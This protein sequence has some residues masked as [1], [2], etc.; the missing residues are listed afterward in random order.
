MRTVHSYKRFSDKQQEDGDSERRQD[1]GA[2][3]YCEK[4]GYRLSDLSFWDKGKSAFSGS[5]QKLLQEFLRIMHAND[6]RV[7][8]SHRSPPV[9]LK[10]FS[11]GDMAY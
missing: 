7:K 6:G 11:A 2:V 3:K 8:V 10:D 9:S 1:D 5:K 4:H